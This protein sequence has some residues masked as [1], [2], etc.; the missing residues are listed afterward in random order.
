MPLPLPATAAGYLDEEASATKYRPSAPRRNRRREALPDAGRPDRCSTGAMSGQPHG[1]NTRIEDVRAKAQVSRGT[2]YNYYPGIEALLEALS[3]EV[4]GLSIP[5]STRRSRRSTVPWR[6]RRQRCATTCT[7]H[8]STVAGAGRSSTRVSGERCIRRRSRRACVSR[9]RRA[10]TPAISRWTLPTWARHPA[11]HWDFRDHQHAAGWDYARTILKNRPPG[12]VELR[13][14]EV[15]SPLH[16]RPCRWIS[17]RVWPQTV[18][19]SA[20]CWAV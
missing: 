14:I 18:V 7:R 6:A 10:S 12:V 1:R 9:F 15:W 16:S 11:R 20:G 3:D 17:Y 2:F 8:S 5:Q 13:R 4:T 19:F